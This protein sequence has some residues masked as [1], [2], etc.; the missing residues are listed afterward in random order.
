MPKNALP[1]PSG[2]TLLLLL[3]SG[4]PLV[5][6]QKLFRGFRPNG[7]GSTDD[8]LHAPK[9]PCGLPLHVSVPWRIALMLLVLAGQ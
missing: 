5:H 1:Q 2:H 6:L 3:D 9:S 8:V 4:T 7:T